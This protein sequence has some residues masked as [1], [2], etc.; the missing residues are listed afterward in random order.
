MAKKTGALE[1]SASRKMKRAI[2]D[3]FLDNPANTDLAAFVTLKKLEA[4]IQNLYAD[5]KRGANVEF[6]R[7]DGESAPIEINGATISKYTKPSK[8]KYTDAIIIKESEL[9]SAKEIEQKTGKAIKVA[10]E[11]NPDKDTKFQVK[12]K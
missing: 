6:D 11:F 9:K 3:L 4:L 2:D 10:E 7:Q 1:E 12:I 8:W 5:I